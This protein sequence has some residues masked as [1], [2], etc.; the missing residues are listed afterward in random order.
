[1]VEIRRNLDDRIA[2][3]KRNRWIGEVEGLKVSLAAADE[4]LAQLAGLA[5]RAVAGQATPGSSN[6]AGR[7]AITPSTSPKGAFS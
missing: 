7:T 3:A 6:F 2:E 1:L 5:A 4:R